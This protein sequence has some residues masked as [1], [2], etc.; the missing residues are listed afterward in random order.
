MRI[1]ACLWWVVSALVCVAAGCTPIGVPVSPS[2]VASPTSVSIPPTSTM[3]A[4][5]STLPVLNQ[6]FPDPDI[7]RVEDFYYAFAT[8]SGGKNIQAA[9]S[10]DLID[11]EILPDALPKVPGWALKGDTWAPDVSYLAENNEYLMYFTVRSRKTGRQCIGWAI[12]SDP[13]G[14][15]LPF[16]DEPLICQVEEGGSI[17]PSSFIDED[18]KRYILWKNDGNCCGMQTYLYIQKTAPDG[19]S[20]LDEPVRLIT[21]DQTWE[22]SLVEAPTLWK[23]AE[24]Y[25]LFYSANTYGNEA[26]ACGVA[27]SS[28]LLGPYEKNKNPVLW[29][30][31]AGTDWIGPGGQD[32]FIGPDN[33]PL[34]AFHG[35][36]R[37]KIKRAMYIQPITWQ[38]GQPVVE[39]DR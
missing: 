28:S 22:G 9:R 18:G 16:D 29:S 10:K 8:I 32:I 34:I 30:N 33:T 37:F 17:D 11:W 20:L 23:Q 2:T 38:D 39:H 27:V 31:M 24:K 35:W 1:A 14:P 36:D 12:S 21:A 5:S 25:Y 13:G 26:Y 3:K 19:K 6:D 7:L 15:Y 4:Q